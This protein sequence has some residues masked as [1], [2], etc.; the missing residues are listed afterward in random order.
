MDWRDSHLKF[1]S[2]LQDENRKEP[3]FLYAMPFSK[4]RIFFEETSLVGRPALA[5]EDLK[6]RLY[7]RLKHLNVKVR[8]VCVSQQRRGISI[9]CVCGIRAVIA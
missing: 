7:A 9:G 8:C 6:D 5:F 1:Y 3:T 4:K 2:E